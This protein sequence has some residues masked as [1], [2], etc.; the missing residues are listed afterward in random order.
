[1]TPAMTAAVTAMT[2]AMTAAV[3]AMTAAMTAMTAAV[4]A[5][6][7]AVTAMTAAVTA[8]HGCM[9][10]RGPGG[11]RARGALPHVYLLQDRSVTPLRGLLTAGVTLN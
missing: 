5:M 6:T 4:T 9:T 1:M 11:H 3:T 2:A 10:G 7:A 8:P